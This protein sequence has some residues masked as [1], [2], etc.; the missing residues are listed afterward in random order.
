MEDFLLTS[1]LK[2]QCEEVGL[3][4]PPAAGTWARNDLLHWATNALPAI[5][6]HSFL[7][8]QLLP[9]I[10]WRLETH[11]SGRPRG[12]YP[13]TFNMSHS[14]DSTNSRTCPSWSCLQG[15]T[16]H[17]EGHPHPPQCDNPIERVREE[18]P[19]RTYMD[20]G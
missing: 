12:K 18:V 6:K 5:Q 19:P 2:L 20:V 16:G 14:K 11:R 7:G 8:F 4:I 13:N 17:A 3:R 1:A 9:T 10:T 15:F